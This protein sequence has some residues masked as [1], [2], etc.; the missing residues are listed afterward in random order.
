MLSWCLLFEYLSRETKLNL[1]ACALTYG[2]K[3]LTSSNVLEI[4]L[5]KLPKND[6]SILLIA[7]KQLYALPSKAKESVVRL[8]QNSM[9][10]H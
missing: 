8:Y 5:N 6:Y 2:F 4:L 10:R 3:N 9:Y 7:Q 1:L